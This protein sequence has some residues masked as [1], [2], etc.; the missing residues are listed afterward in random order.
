M[1][2]WI[3]ILSATETPRL[4][5]FNTTVANAWLGI[6]LKVGGGRAWAARGTLTVHV[7]TVTQLA[8]TTL[9]PWYPSS[10]TL[11]LRPPLF[12]SAVVQPC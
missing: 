5:D 1:F 7:R 8:V 4:K 6:K 9:A 10:A 2:L 11:S 12:L 3:E